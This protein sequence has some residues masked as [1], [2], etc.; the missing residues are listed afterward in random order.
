MSFL[1]NIHL[2]FLNFSSEF[3]G[4]VMQS[5]ARQN[6]EPAE[7]WKEHESD[8]HPTS[9]AEREGKQGVLTLF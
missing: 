7:T 2:D 4:T 5:P 1:K 8:S 9:D 3:K 6:Q